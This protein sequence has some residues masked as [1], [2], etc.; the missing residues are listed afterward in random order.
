MSSTNVCI[1][2][3]SSQYITSTGTCET[4]PTG[5]KPL[6]NSTCVCTSA[7]KYFVVNGTTLSCESCTSSQYYSKKTENC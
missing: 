5:S 1:K 6:Y 3:T 4:C 7:K 2:C